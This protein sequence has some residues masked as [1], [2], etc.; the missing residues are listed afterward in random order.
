[1][2]NIY[3]I[4]LDTTVYGGSYDAKTGLLTV[5]HILALFDGSNDEDWSVYGT[6]T[7]NFFYRCPVSQTAVN[8]K[9]LCNRFTPES[10]FP[11]GT[12]L[13]VYVYGSQVR[14][15]T[16]NELSLDNWKAF[17]A[18]NNVQVV[19]PLETPITIQLSP[20]V[21]NTIA[22]KQNNVFA[23]TGDVTECKYYK[24]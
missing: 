16:D 10:I 17:L 6:G 7:E 19:Y 4:N 21:I 18:S 23:S 3:T 13:G 22:N 1:M 12:R 24:K 11:T 14:I 5:T 20:V 15:R 9:P 8:G 2:I